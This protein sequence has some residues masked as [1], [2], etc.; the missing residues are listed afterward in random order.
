MGKKVE[1][2]VTAV[3]TASITITGVTLLS[4]KEAQM[5]PK[6]IRKAKDSWGSARPA[7]KWAKDNGIL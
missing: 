1:K 4:A 7:S 2:L 5:L 3:E 6:E